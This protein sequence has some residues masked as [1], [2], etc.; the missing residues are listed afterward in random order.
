[1]W[2]CNSDGRRRDDEVQRLPR[3]PVVW[4]MGVIV[5]H[6]VV[7]VVL[8]AASVGPFIVMVMAYVIEIPPARRHLP[9]RNTPANHPSNYVLL[10][11]QFS[12]SSIHDCTSSSSSRR[13]PRAA[14][15]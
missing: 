13:P 5:F 14:G 10:V 6:A 12:G 3:R 4:L 2:K 9:N 1:M 7:A 15:E 8:E 11:L